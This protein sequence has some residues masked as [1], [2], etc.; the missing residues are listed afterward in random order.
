MA[1]GKQSTFERLSSGHLNRQQ[2]WD[3]ARKLTAEHP[4][5]DI[6]KKNAAGIDVGNEGHCAAVPP[7]CDPEPVREF[8]GWTADLENAKAG[9]WRIPRAF[10]PAL[11]QR[12]HL[13][14]VF[15][16]TARGAAMVAPSDSRGFP[17]R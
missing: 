4:G 3:L 15:S 10:D 8:G 17:S 12:T 1:N 5:L 14:R 11:L 9:L 7:N 6:V 16:A 2:R 13:L